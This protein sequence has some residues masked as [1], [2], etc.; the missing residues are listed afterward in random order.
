VPS[1]DP[2]ELLRTQRVL[3]GFEAWSRGDWSYVQEWLSSDCKWEENHVGGF[4][5]LDRVY[6]GPEGFAK[7]LHD[8]RE[9]WD[10][11]TSEAE[12]VIEVKHPDGPTF[13][14][15]TRLSARGRQEIQVDWVLFNVLWTR[16]A[17]AIVRR[18]IYFDREE[19]FAQAA[20]SD[21]EIEA[22]DLAD[23]DV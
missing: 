4:P 10:A 19:A 3:A 14:V 20:L 22:G 17:E 15:A 21:S 13:V 11:I 6:V 12:E 5:G 7:W 18:R 9:A 16:N 8:T 23:G 2:D 1:S